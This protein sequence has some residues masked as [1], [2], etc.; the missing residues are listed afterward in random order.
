MRSSSSASRLLVPG[1][2]A[3]ISRQVPHSGN[4]IG[5]PSPI[6]FCVVTLPAAKAD[7]QL[8][9]RSSSWSKALPFRNELIRSSD[10][11]DLRRATSSRKKSPNIVISCGRMFRYPL[12]RSA[13]VED[14]RASSASRPGSSTGMPNTRQTVCSAYGS[15]KS[16]TR[17][18]S[19]LSRSG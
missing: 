19:P 10:G 12:V 14:H 13:T 2:A 15:E 5:T 17:S 1:F 7:M 16:F 3:T 9:T 8:T 11:E 18:S 4:S 6:S